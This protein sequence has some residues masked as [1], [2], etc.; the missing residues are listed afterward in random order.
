MSSPL[1]MMPIAL[2]L[3]ACS[4][5]CGR[6]DDSEVVRYVE[7]VGGE[8]QRDTTSPGRPVIGVRYVRQNLDRFELKL[9]HLTRLKELEQLQSVNLVNLTISQPEIVELAKL[10]NLKK[11][12]SGIDEAGM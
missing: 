5:T 2:T 9:E 11:L 8:V 3:L 1:R 12:D 7:S 4:I 6:A 10:P